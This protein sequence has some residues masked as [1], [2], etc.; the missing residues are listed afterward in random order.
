MQIIEFADGQLPRVLERLEDHVDGRMLWLDF[1][2]GERSD[3]HELAQQ[4]SGA[5]LLQQ[6]MVELE[7]EEHLQEINLVIFYLDV[8]IRWGFQIHH[9]Q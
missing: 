6:H 3:W 9:F 5:T 8:Y 2:R 4:L 7:Q 1:V